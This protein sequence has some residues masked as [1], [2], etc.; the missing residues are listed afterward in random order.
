MLFFN[1]VDDE[2]DVESL[3]VDVDE[4]DKESLDVDVNKEDEEEEEGGGG[5]CD[6]MYCVMILSSRIARTVCESSG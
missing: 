6:V 5:G 3:D 4:D 1:V 2:E